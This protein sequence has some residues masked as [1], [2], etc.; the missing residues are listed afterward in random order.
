MFSETKPALTIHFAFKLT[1]KVIVK[2]VQEVIYPSRIGV[3]FMILIVLNMDLI[4]LA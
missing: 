1:Y 2:N 4:G 3:F